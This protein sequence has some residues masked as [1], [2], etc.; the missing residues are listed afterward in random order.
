MTMTDTPRK[1]I[2]RA[3]VYDAETI[4]RLS[5][6][7]YRIELG[8]KDAA[9]MVEKDRDGGAKLHRRAQAYASLVRSTLDALHAEEKA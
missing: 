8:E 1:P 2:P 6:R 9:L 5:E 3:P 4:A 7:V